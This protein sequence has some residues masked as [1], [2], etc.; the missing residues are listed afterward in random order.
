M[1]N[2]VGRKNSRHEREVNECCDSEHGSRGIRKSSTF[3]IWKDAA[4]CRCHVS[5]LLVLLLLD[6]QT[7]GPS[8]QPP[9]CVVTAERVRGDS[10]RRFLNERASQSPWPDCSA[11]GGASPYRFRRKSV[12]SADVGIRGPWRARSPSQRWVTGG[13]DTIALTF[14]CRCVRRHLSLPLG[15][16][17]GAQILDVD[18]EE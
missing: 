2:I 6:N 4:A 3:F 13:G 16:G 8:V 7:R 5:C 9:R 10:G 11:R 17:E 18:L 15:L 1:H 12:S 14:F